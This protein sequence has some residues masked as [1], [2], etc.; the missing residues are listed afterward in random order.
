MTTMTDLQKYPRYGCLS[1]MA[2]GILYAIN[3]TFHLVDVGQLF[4]LLMAAGGAI[5]IAWTLWK[6]LSVVSIEALAPKKPL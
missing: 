6:L 1:L 3:E 2:F 5:V 4:F